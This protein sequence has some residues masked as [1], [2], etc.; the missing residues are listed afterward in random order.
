M[1]ES[2]YFPH[3]YNA[4]SDPKLQQVLMDVGIEGI[5]IYWCLIEMLY[6]QDGILPISS[7]KSIAFALH[8]HC[9]C[10]QSI[11]ND[12]GL[13]N[14]DGDV[15]WSESVK[16]RL[17]KR[18]DISNKRKEAAISRWKSDKVMQ[19]Q[20]NCIDFECKSNAI[21]E[22]ERKGN[23]KETIPIGIEKKDELSFSSPKSLADCFN[24]ISSQSS[25]IEAITMNTH[26]EYPTFNKQTLIE[27]LKAFFRKLQNEGETEKT[28]KDAMSHFARWL[29]IE[30][31]EKKNEQTNGNNYA[32]RKTSANE[33]ALRQYEDSRRKALSG[34]RE[35]KSELFGI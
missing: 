10:V 8:V 26:S 19:K 18:C 29:K 31:K 6:E 7:C 25:W 15:F 11:I 9:N 22:K 34:V 21:K 32:D 13:F 30:L 20:C 23:N 27:M 17:K 24:L 28:P 2:F 35:D 5:G 4:R 1:N 12:F 33:A 3:D 14:S 16:K